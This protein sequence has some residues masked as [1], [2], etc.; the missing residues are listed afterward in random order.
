[1]NF[2]F[3]GTTTNIDVLTVR[4]FFKIHVIII[5]EGKRGERNE[6]HMMSKKEGRREEHD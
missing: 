2:S 1:M 5:G 3:N 6:V 4:T